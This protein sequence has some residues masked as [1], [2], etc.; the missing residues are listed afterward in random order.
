[1]RNKLLF[2]IPVL[3][4]VFIVVIYGYSQSS[5]YAEIDRL[6]ERCNDLSK[7]EKDIR[8]CKIHLYESITGKKYEK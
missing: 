3:V 6:Y 1:M 4:I 5:M 7:D 2:F 8:D